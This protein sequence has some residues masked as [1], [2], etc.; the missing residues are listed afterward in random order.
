MKLRYLGLALVLFSLS[1]TATLLLTPS[2]QAVPNAPV[3]PFPGA[4]GYLPTMALGSSCSGGDYL[5][6]S[7][8]SYSE[9]KAMLATFVIQAMDARHC[10]YGDWTLACRPAKYCFG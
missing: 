3:A 1:G 2:A 6:G 8:R 10:N 5:V 7:A 4:C 9:C